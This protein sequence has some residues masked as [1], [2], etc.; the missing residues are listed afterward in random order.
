MD[1]L[2]YDNYEIKVKDSSLLLSKH[3]ISKSDVLTNL[4]NDTL[5]DSNMII[6]DDNFDIESLRKSYT[7]YQEIKDLMIKDSENN[8]ISFVDYI[9]NNLGD[10]KD[11]YSSKNIEIPHFEVFKKY[12]ESKD[13]MSNFKKIIRFND[14]LNLQSIS[15]MMSP[16]ISNLLINLPYDTKVKVFKEMRIKLGHLNRDP[17]ETN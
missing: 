7:Y 4:I 14:Y 8:D 13:F 16:I 12:S 1:K 3:F 2:K 11:R 5:D 10:I 15:R 6:L 17:D 9:E